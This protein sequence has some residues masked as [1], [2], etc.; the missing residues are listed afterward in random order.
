MTKRSIRTFL[1]TGLTLLLAAVLAACGSSSSSSSSSGG[2]APAAAGSTS[3]A[4]NA[5]AASGGTGVKKGLRLAFFSAGG[6]NT[7]LQT[8]IKAA[9][10]TAAKYG[11]SIHVFTGNFDGALQL[12]QVMGAISSQ[13]YDGF[14]LEPINSQQLCSAVKAALAAKI[15][16]GI[17]NVPACTAAYDKPYP[18]TA[19]FVGG[20]SPAAYRQ[21][22]QE[23]FQANPKGGQFGV[24][25]GPI[26]QG[27]SVRAQQVLQQVSP[28]FQ[29][30]KQVGFQP[31][32]YQASVALTKA[33]NMLQAN[34]N[35]SLLFSNYSGQTPGAIS[36]ITAAG[37]TGKVAIYDLGGDKT[38]FDAIK[39]GSVA[40]TEVYLPYEE[41][42]RAVQAVVAK[43]SGL[44]ELDQVKV[45]QFW[46]LTK[47][48]KL[49]GLSPFVTKATISKYAGVGL[50]EY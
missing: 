32:E 49:G 27:N 6:N 20:Q 12:N 11:A 15:V 47:D 44:P 3:G 18:G 22:Y 23:G 2:G 10:E 28:Q 19:I 24:L 5:N 36:A 42:Q 50:P 26:T 7:Y 43:L 45:G 31:T 30:W 40:S 38:M 33:Q 13:S 37:K 35:M 1:A 29:Q 41:Q 48:P 4:S 39:N 8:G 9:Q 17:D 25:V 46:D 16:I 14:I 21:W 34:P